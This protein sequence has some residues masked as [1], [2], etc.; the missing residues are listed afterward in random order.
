MEMIAYFR[1]K[2]MLKVINLGMYIG[3]T[4]LLVFYAYV[5]VISKKYNVSDEYKL[6]YI[7]QVLNEYLPAGGLAQY[8]PG[9][10]YLYTVDGDSG[11]R[12]VD[13]GGID[14]GTWACGQSA[15]VYFYVQSIDDVIFRIEYNKSGGVDN[16]L[17]VN[18]HYAGDIVVDKKIGYSCNDVLVNQKLLVDG[19][20]EFKLVPVEEV[21]DSFEN[22]YV[23]S[24]GTYYVD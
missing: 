3:A 7:D 5:F 20:N 11:N 14:E 4:I 10:Q 19:L 12:S 22:L 1:M 2:K 9:R 8:Q 6:F 17:Y 13:F 18:G 21:S 24:V 16:H 15:K 23:Y